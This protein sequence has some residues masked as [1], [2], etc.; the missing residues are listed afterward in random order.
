MGR[1]GRGPHLKPHAA[2]DSAP[3]APHNGPGM[4][5]HFTSHVSA[6]LPSDKS[7]D[8]C[9]VQRQQEAVIAVLADGA[10]SGDPAREAAQRAVEM[11]AGHYAS[12]PA[13][14]TPDR[15]LTE[16]VLLL[17]RTFCGESKARFGRREMVSTLA[18]AVMEGDTLHGLN[19]GDSRV[20]LFRAGALQQ[21]S[22]DHTDPADDNCLISGL[23]I[24]DEPELH[25]FRIPLV[26]GDT[27]LLASDGVWKNLTPEE[28]TA[29]LD[30]QASAR[31]L[32]VSAREKATAV[33]LDDMSAI[34]MEVLHVGRLPGRRD[35]PLPVLTELRKGLQVDGWTLLRPLGA[36]D[37][38]WLAEKDAQRAVLKFPPADA[39]RDESLLEAFIREVWNAT[40]IEADWFVHAEEPEGATARYYKM[41]FIEAP[42]LKQLLR[43]RR[44]AVDEAVELGKFLAAAAQHL[45]RFDLVHGDIKPENILA[46]TNYDR[47]R[48][49]LVDMGSTVPVFSTV[50]RSGTA[51]Y[52]A[53]ERF[54][55]APVSE[56]TELYAMGVTLYEAL[57]G[58]LPFGEIERYQTPHFTSARPPSAF[59]PNV[60]P[61]LDS[62]ILRACAVDP[63]RRCQHY[64]E[65]SYD[66]THPDKVA[67]WR[68]PGAPL[69]QTNPLLF[70]KSACFLLLGVILLLLLKLARIW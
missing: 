15:A 22:E 59:N 64:S 56:R 65:I 47:L 48:F 35:T 17:N 27:V 53:P 62:V 26:D 66:L 34:V 16:I 29:A 9:A 12:R 13:A 23:G 40:R 14:W 50:S 1:G 45:L 58:R 2:D 42:G 31:S 36:S 25:R 52:L 7:S 10:G 43:S 32:V 60:P 41:E 3:G 67:P 24:A 8:A 55:G 33:T 18:V 21:L 68:V 49:K 69:L 63:A 19:A 5:V 28:I 44:L 51:S 30:S 20:W 46:D 4:T 6:R 70:Y 38:C 61:W 57:T 54:N 37:C 11:L 39:A